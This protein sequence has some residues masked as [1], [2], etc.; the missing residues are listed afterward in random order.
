MKKIDIEDIE[1]TIS[2][3]LKGNCCLQELTKDIS[4]STQTPRK[5][6]RRQVGFPI[7]AHIENTR[8][9][10]MVALLENTNMLCKNIC[11]EVG[12]REDS[13]ARAFKREMGRT[14][15]EWR[16]SRERSKEENG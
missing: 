16:M 8:L 13:G 1:N 2:V 14:M 7:S 3:D 5:Q 12:L 11:F 9:A 15:M 10:W 4:V 6:F